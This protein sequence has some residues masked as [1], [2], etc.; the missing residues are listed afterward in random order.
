MEERKLGS[1]EKVD[2]RK[3]WNNEETDFTRWL[4]EEDNMNK[5]GEEIGIEIKVNKIEA[6]VGKFR[7]DILAE[8]ENTGRKI[9]IEN[10]L[11]PTDH[12]HL[13]KI[14]TYSSGYDA[15]IIIW[16]VKDMRDEHK[17]AI[18]WL[19][20]HTDED[21]NI[22]IVKIEVW[23][24]GNS[25]PAPNFEIISQPNDWAKA[26]KKYTKS[27]EL[28]ETK[29]LQLDFWNDFKEYAKKEN[30]NLSLRKAR[31]Q[32]WYDI[33]IGFSGVHMSLTLNTR[34]DMMGVEIYIPNNK[35]LF[36]RLKENKN[37]IENEIGAEL[38]WMELPDKKASRIKISKSADI[39]DTEEWNNYFAW[40]KSNA[41]KFKKVFYKHIRNVR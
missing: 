3:I 25:A 34:D 21:I 1:I 23:K 7:A 16:V 17:Q 5:L 30:T 2:L 32:H 18:D 27:D 4:A 10:Q 29:M 38:E 15:K 31:P 8:E 22:F 26:L 39:N 37:I 6:N 13:G 12:S 9:I 19:N 14:I 41:E 28:T 20:E 35:E 33:S 36:N 24:I 11:E 40:L